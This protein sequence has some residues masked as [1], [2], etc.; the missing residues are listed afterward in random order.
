MADDIKLVIDVDDRSVI[1][2]IKNQEK[3]EKEIMDTAKGLKRLKDALA[4]GMISQSKF[5]KGTA[6]VN[7]RISHLTK[8][9][10]SG[11]GAVDQWATHVNQAKN[12]TNRF[13][14][15]AQQVG[16]Q[17]GDF[18]VQVQSG[19]SA[20][21]AFGQQGT[22]LAGLLPGVAGAVVG[23]GLSLGT[24]LL[25]TFLDTKDAGK[26][27]EE[28]VKAVEEALSDLSNVSSMLRDT[29]GAPF[30]EA[31]TV[32]REYLELLEKSSA[33]NVQKQ[34]S[35]AF[36]AKG[37]STGIL[38]ELAL[39]AEDMQRGDLSWNLFEGLN[40]DATEKE[41]EDANE[42]L[43]V[44]GEIAE[45][46]RGTAAQPRV[47]EGAEGLRKLG[48]DLLAYSKQFNGALGERIRT[49]MFE[50]GLTKLMVDAEKAKGDAA[51]DALEEH[52]TEMEA[53]YDMIAKEDKDEAKRKSD[54]MKK[55]WDAL[56]K[57][58]M[59]AKK[60]ADEASKREATAIASSKV[61]IEQASVKQALQE[62]E[63]QYG[64]KSI[65]HR[66]A[67]VKA[68][69]ELARITAKQKFIADGITD[70]EQDQ[71]DLLV[72]AA[73]EAEVMRQAL[74]DSKVEAQDLA[75]ALKAVEAS[76]DRLTNIGAGVD[77][78]IA[79][80]R[81][82]AEALQEG[83]G[84]TGSRT[85]GV[86]AGITAEIES[87][88]KATN[89]AAQAAYD[90]A[91][92]KIMITVGQ[93]ASQFEML[94]DVDP[95][96]ERAARATRDTALRKARD[97]RQ[98]RITG[99]DGGLPTLEFYM[100][101]KARLE[102]EEKESNKS[103]SKGKKKPGLIMT[104]EL[105][106]M[107]QKLD[108]QTAS[109]GKSEEEILFEQNKSQLLSKI[110]DQMVGMSEVDKAFYIQQAEGAA[111]YITNKQLELIALQEIEQQQEKVADTI[112]NSMGN[113]LMSMVD[114][115]MSVK[116][117]FKSMASDII[118]DLYRILVVEQMVK[119]IKT[120]TLGFFEDG[121]VFQGG[122]QVQAYADGGVV[123]SPTTF[124]MAGGRTGLMGEAG[125]EAIMPLKRG[126]NGKLGVQV[127]G[128]NKS[129]NIVIHQNFNFQAN[130]DESV[131][132]IIA[133]SAPQL[134]NMTQRQIM[135]SR[136]RGGQM[137]STFG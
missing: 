20:L 114:G 62:A 134:A 13:G 60:A 11:A 104:E 96:V 12:K 70:A 69:K 117:A 133:E 2:S 24:M 71:I 120:A 101:E 65:E 14:M 29:L 61:Q 21:V 77:K 9:L 102:A 32:L 40:Y 43:R 93:G 136:R 97:L 137:R 127:E 23:I 112:A 105:F 135:E 83:K 67:Q 126:A 6:Q 99:F 41:I 42:L 54:L 18:F 113:A 75:R 90:L 80:L 47:I 59:E 132:R 28:S 4:T 66:E 100:N 121:G 7:S 50:S 51:N 124:P 72:E 128:G 26:Q 129:E 45:I 85:A 34:V 22:Q 46:L 81:A 91:T 15:V 5:D 53:F 79:V 58:R 78:R 35:L 94:T 19:T 110:T 57:N 88:F 64:S 17:V 31:N 95:S 106:A 44:R 55:Q 36:G 8:T 116:D 109:L 89:E 73:G 16:Y 56:Y 38:N 52:A 92:K 115:T 130:G 37:E 30:S 48:D 87:S 103:G 108:L 122:S 1:K 86:I 118:K 125:P 82:E 3:L 76:M 107:K 119:S 74:A 63:L 10:Y 39:M 98:E 131:K 25:K 27:L 123:G 68:A 111:E 33:A 84:L 49:L